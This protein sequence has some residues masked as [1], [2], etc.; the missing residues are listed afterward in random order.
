MAKYG[1]SRALETNTRTTQD[2]M[3]ITLTSKEFRRDFDGAADTLASVV[4][5]NGLVVACGNGGSFADADHVVGELSGWYEH[6]QRRAVDAVLL[7]GSSATLT[8]IGNDVGYE[9]IFAR[10]LEGR[11]QGL[12]DRE[13]I[14]LA[15]STSGNSPNVVKA[16][17]VANQ[18]N[19]PSI[20]FT[21]QDG[22][23]LKNKVTYLLAVP[24]PQTPRVQE[25][26][27]VLYHT[28]CGVVDE[29]LREE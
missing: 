25:V 1:A 17:E 27:T 7:G 12:H 13:A 9:E 5:N 3:S 14:V 6:K 26:H 19:V 10:E 16:I 18:Y 23:A 28:L 8:A 15:F 20:G 29:A 4:R 22:G 24:S 21:G 2:L 11:L